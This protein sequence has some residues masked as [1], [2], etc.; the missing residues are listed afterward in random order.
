[1]CDTIPLLW[2]FYLYMRHPENSI[3]IKG[4]IILSQPTKMMKLMNLK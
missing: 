4:P 3:V 1:M 2:N